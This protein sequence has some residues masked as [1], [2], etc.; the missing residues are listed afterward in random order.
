[1]VILSTG[2]LS[3]SGADSLLPVLCR[4]FADLHQGFYGEIALKQHYGRFGTFGV[5]DEF[6][7][8]VVYRSVDVYEYV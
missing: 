6:G 8:P 4:E 3:V 5:K 1:M 2:S 7:E